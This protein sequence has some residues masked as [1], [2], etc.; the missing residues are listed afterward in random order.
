MV[1]ASNPNLQRVIRQALYRLKLQFGV[2]V[3]VYEL[4]NTNTNYNTGVKTREIERVRVRRAIKLPQQTTH[5]Q[6]ISPNYTQ[7]NKSFVTKGMGWDEV[8]DT[9][10]FDGTDLPNFDFQLKDC[11]LVWNHVRYEI[12]VIEEMGHRAGWVVGTTLAKGTPANEFHIELVEQDVGL[13]GSI[14]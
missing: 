7:T 5:K 10:L 11:W 8:S 14:S 12:K 2:L 4:V 1:P 3:D 6:F 13:S 9:F